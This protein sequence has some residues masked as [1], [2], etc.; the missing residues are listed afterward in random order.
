M[1]EKN[2][3]IGAISAAHWK[4]GISEENQVLR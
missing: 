3:P 4:I 2:L 1:N